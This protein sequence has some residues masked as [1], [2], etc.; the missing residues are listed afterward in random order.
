MP[1]LPS[2]QRIFIEKRLKQVK[3][4]VAGVALVTEAVQMGSA[5]FERD[6]GAKFAHV[7]NDVTVPYGCR[8]SAVIRQLSGQH[9]KQQE[10]DTVVTAE[11][12]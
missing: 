9:F 6:A 5:L 1:A 11:G 7:G 8:H 3:Q 2:P 4:R 12:V 10:S